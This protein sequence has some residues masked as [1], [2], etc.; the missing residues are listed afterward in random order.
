MSV[1]HIVLCSVK[2]EQGRA[3]YYALTWQPS[4]VGG[5]IVERSWGRWCSARRQQKVNSVENQDEAVAFVTGHLRRRLRHEYELVEADAD[6]RALV[7]EQ[8]KN[9]GEER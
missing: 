8:Q 2:P 9:R 3:R 6:G 4:L 1:G 5:W 7:G